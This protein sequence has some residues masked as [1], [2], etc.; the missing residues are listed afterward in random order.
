MEILIQEMDVL[1]NVRLRRDIT[2]HEI[3]RHYARLN[4]LMELKQ[5]MKNA[6]M[7][8]LIM[9]MDVQMN[10]LFQ[11]KLKRYKKLHLLQPKH[12]SSYKPPQLLF[13]QS[14][15][16]SISSHLT[17]QSSYSLN[18]IK[19]NESLPSLQVIKTSSFLMF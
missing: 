18:Q 6:M 9:R 12:P 3:F 16:Q 5:V 13:Q 2:V 11:V 15:Q 14:V 10:V 19:K 4:V 8:I 7:G 1:I 17:Q